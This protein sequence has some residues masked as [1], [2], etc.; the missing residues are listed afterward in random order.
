MTSSNHG[1]DLYG[2]QGDAVPW[3]STEAIRRAEYFTEGWSVS[4]R[5]SAAGRSA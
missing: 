3:N 5:Y 1:V 4:V 2:S